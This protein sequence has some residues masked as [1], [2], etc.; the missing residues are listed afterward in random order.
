MTLQFDAPLD[1]ARG[2]VHGTRVLVF[3]ATGYIGAHLVP[4]LLREGCEVRA[5]GR[6]R[7]VL[8]AR[9]WP[10]VELVEADALLPDS[11]VSVLAGVDTA[12][13]LVHSMA[14]GANFG[15]LD[16]KA[17][18]N[19]AAA[20]DRAGV[21]RIVYLGGLIPEG[22]DSEHLLS[23]RDTGER[24]RAGRVPVTEIRAGIIVGPGSAAYEVIRDLVNHLPLMLTPR[25][26]QSKS[27]PIA[28]DNLL[29]YLV[30]V[31][32]LDEAAGRVLDAGGAEYLS[33]EQLMR[34][35]GEVV[36]KRPRII[37]V[38]VLTPRL[39]A[40]WL[41]L[42]T[43][44]P[45]NIARA[46]IGGLKHDLPA[47]DAELRRLVPIKLLNF[48]ESVS[49][50]LQ[51]EM[52]HSVAARWSEGLLMFRGFRL[53]NAF[54]A[55]RASGYA[56]GPAT[57]EAVWQ[58]VATIGGDN[59]Y[60]CM[61]WLWL[62]R[63]VMDWLVGGPGL[64][65]GRRHP[66]ELRIGDRVDYWTVLALEPGKRLTLHF[67]MRAPGSGVMELEVAPAPSSPEPTH[68]HCTRLT[69]TAYWHP[70]G[71]WGLLYWYALVPAHLF[72]FRAMAK[73]MLRRAQ[74]IDATPPPSNV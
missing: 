38:P 27:S 33:Y 46:L 71:V 3:G 41:G 63:G 21:R 17:A 57:A 25:W 49:A 36:G 60:Y 48:R 56:V 1:Q 39:S 43:A 61:S 4:R 6:N 72:I 42:V 20:A 28:L 64:T 7:Q 47:R 67:G 50:A 18:G 22:A 16:I 11:L 24:L 31:A 70:Q 45:S 53:D 69:V 29:E 51:A 12:Y 34:Q 40:H 65:R 2:K 54:Y 68:S 52:T 73:A 32:W 26:V 44:V 37:A 19:F 5:S 74:Q 62:I 59:G 14:A 9:D 8:E 35:F 23:R 10:D 58:T 13:Y 66:T 15:Q 55:K 30:C